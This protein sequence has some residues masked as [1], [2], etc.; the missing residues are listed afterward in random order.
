M[1]ENKPI[2]NEEEAKPPSNEQQLNNSSTD[3]PIAEAEQPITHNPP[4]VTEQDMEVHHHAHDPAAPHH[5]KNWK[6]YFWE[7]LML[8]LA[9]FCGF[10]AENQ[11]EHYIEKL[12]AKEYARSLLKDLQK[13]TADIRKASLYEERISNMIDSVVGFI[14]NPATDQKTGRL[15]YY[16]RM[17]C[18]RYNVDWN[19]ST[20]NQLINSGNLRYFTNSQ[21][22]SSIS[23]YNTLANMITTYDENIYEKN[24]KA[25]EYKYQIL[26]AK[27][28]QRLSVLSMDDVVHGRKQ[29]FIDSIN[30]SDLPL[31]KNAAEMLN[32]FANALLDTKSN[33]NYLQVKNY[34]QATELA[35]T[36][37][38]L[39]KKEYHLE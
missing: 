8:F 28:E 35:I 30:H 7:F 25:V 2:H 23:N 12:R 10:L 1:E 3:E 32:A 27:Y 22:V 31:Q 29:A 39:L 20:M 15:Y 13:D 21:L 6:S 34:P 26:V 36:I 11:R 17:A 37:M 19:K 9:V 4:P 5:K 24:N 33:R 38:E 16:M 18:W 14:S